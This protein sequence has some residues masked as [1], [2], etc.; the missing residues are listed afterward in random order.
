MSKWALTVRPKTD[1]RVWDLSSVALHS[2][3]RGTSLDG[4]A[5][6]AARSSS[7]SITCGLNLGLP[8]LCLYLDIY[9][10][11]GDA[12]V[13]KPPRCKSFSVTLNQ[14]WSVAGTINCNVPE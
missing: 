14:H 9:V 5:C 10:R 4:K 7:S 1:D 11:I 3:L 12:A 2:Q 6:L 13:L 8:G